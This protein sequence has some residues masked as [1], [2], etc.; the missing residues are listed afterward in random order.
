MLGL[1]L[2]LMGGLLAQDEADWTKTIMYFPS[3]ELKANPGGNESSSSVP[4]RYATKLWVA[5]DAKEDDS[6]LVHT[7]AQYEGNRYCFIFGSSLDLQYYRYSVNFSSDVY[8]QISQYL[9]SGAGMDST[10]QNVQ[11][12]T[13]RDIVFRLSQFRQMQTF[14]EAS[15]LA[16]KMDTTLPAHAAREKTAKIGQAA[17]NF[18]GAY[19]H[20]RTAGRE[21]ERCVF[22]M[23]S[24]EVGADYRGAIFY[25]QGKELTEL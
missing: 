3:G 17:S 4:A 1:G 19:Y 24:A 20:N 12:A 11:L 21:Q 14:S 5:T 23:S 18:G 15:L 8:G 22:A 6:V 7:L 9:K 13:R 2:T 16:E 25:V 10:N